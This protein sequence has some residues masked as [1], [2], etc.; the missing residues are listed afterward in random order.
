MEQSGANRIEEYY[1]V[2]AHHH[3]RSPN[4]EKAID[5]LELANL[6]AIK[7]N[8]TADAQIHFE[9]A[10]A[11]YS[12][13]P[14]T[15]E[16]RR[17]RIATLLQQVPVYLLQLE[18][19]RYE[20]LLAAHESVAASV[21]DEGLLGRFY[22]CIGH[23]HWFMGRH[24]EGL[25]CSRKAVALCEKAREMGGAAFAYTLCCVLS[26]SRRAPASELGVL[27]RLHGRVLTV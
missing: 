9:T 12:K 6:K 7:A 18:L 1:E 10:L 8:A 13:L 5:Y 4:I 19:T 3:S 14:D 25:E 17:R 22:G 23:A 11:L 15:L 26:P 24:D 21:E 20:Q 16:N 27:L 2:L